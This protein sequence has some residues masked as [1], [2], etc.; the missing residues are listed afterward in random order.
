MKVLR[1]Q[2]EALVPFYSVFAKYFP[3]GNSLTGESETRVLNGRGSER[4]M[5]SYWGIKAK[6]VVE[7]G[8]ASPRQLQNLLNDL[9]GDP[10][11]GDC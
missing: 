7:Q 8:H 1:E 11:L 3:V 4:Q 5:S 6:L 2:E 10:S 9:P